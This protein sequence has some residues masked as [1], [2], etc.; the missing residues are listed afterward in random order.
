MLVIK[1]TKFVP[2]C[3]QLALAAYGGRS[4]TDVQITMG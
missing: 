4:D 3:I 2:V 1:S